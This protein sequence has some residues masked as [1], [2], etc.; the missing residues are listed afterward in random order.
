MCPEP[1]ASTTQWIVRLARPSDLLS[2]QALYNQLFTVPFYFFPPLQRWLRCRHLRRQVLADNGVYVFQA[3]GRIYGSV[4][5]EFNISGKLATNNLCMRV[6][7]PVNGLTSI[8][9][10]LTAEAIITHCHSQPAHL[11]CDTAHPV[12]VKAITRAF[13]RLGWRLRLLHN[14]NHGQHFEMQLE[15][16]KSPVP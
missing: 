9:P 16:I 10:K 11:V 6:Q 4:W 2:L 1:V 15:P 14:T 7:P 3:H 5:L 8:W 12:L 13:S